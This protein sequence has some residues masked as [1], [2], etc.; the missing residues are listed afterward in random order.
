[1]SKATFTSKGQITIPADVRR[2]LS[3]EVGDRLEFVQVSS[4]GFLLIA[5]NQ[6][7]SSLKGMFGKPP[8]VIAVEDMRS[9]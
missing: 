7:V 8:R 6:C 1:M 2:A 9:V 4:D 3:L 5:V